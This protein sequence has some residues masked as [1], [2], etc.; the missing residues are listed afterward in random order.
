MRTIAIDLG[1]TAVKLGVFESGRLVA[2]DEFA[3]VDGHVGLDDVALRVKALL[4]GDRPAAVGIAVPGVVDPDGSKLLAAHGKYRELHDLD[5][6][7][8]S[9]S[10]L[11]SPAVVE[12]DAR[13]ALIGEI[14]DG[15]A[16][17]SRDAL[18]VV[19]GT[20]IGTAAIVDGRMIRGRRG[21]GAILGGHI[22]LDLYGPRCPCGNVGCAEALA[23]T[24]AFASDAASGR[25]ALG[26]ELAARLAGRSAIGIRDLVETRHESESAAILERYLRVW[27]AVIVT[28]CHAF[29]PDVV[30]VTGGVMRSADVIL[31]SLEQQVHADLWSSSFR[32]PLVTPDDPATSVLRGLAALAD[33]F[34]SKGRP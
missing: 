15:S 25:L 28:Q 24:W 23:S 6:S 31:P 9:E 13:A 4:D 33:D 19:L 2:G 20:G 29:D 21:H 16:R 17:G 22:T 5:L 18:L 10:R 12:N 34:D 7:A 3:T 27:S 14:A 1:G 26:P 8:W 11:G 30:V 32:P